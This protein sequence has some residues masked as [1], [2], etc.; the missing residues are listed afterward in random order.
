MKLKKLEQS[1]S[2]IANGQLNFTSASTIHVKQK[3]FEKI[4]TKTPPLVKDFS[5]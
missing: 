2:R 3:L 5:A 4:E 1:Q